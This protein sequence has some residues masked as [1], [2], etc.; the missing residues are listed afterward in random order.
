[1]KE[2]ILEKIIERASDI[3]KA[4]P[5]TLNQE[6]EFVQFSPK[7]VHYSQMTTYLEDEFDVEV[8]YLGFK[9]CKTFGEAVDYVM[10]L[11]EE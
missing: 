5:D 9:R 6:T 3:W 8:P 4:E 7:S 10:G 2:Q 1:M 11:L